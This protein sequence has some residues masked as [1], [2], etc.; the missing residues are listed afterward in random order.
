MIETARGALVVLLVLTIL[1]LL[2]VLKGHDSDG[3]RSPY[4]I[5]DAATPETS[6]L[7]EALHERI[8][9]FLGWWALCCTL[10][11]IWFR[12]AFGRSARS[13]TTPRDESRPP[14]VD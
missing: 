4:E 13:E 9:K 1:G 14:F 2:F 8:L 6:T 12:G 7:A 5:S 11:L 10:V 3:F